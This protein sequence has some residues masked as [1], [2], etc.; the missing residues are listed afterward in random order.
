MTDGEQMASDERVR[1]VLTTPRSERPERGPLPKLGFWKEVSLSGRLPDRLQN[2][3]KDGFLTQEEAFEAETARVGRMSSKERVE[4]VLS[5]P[6][7]KRPKEGPLEKGTVRFRDTFSVPD[8]LTNEVR[9]G[10]LTLEEAKSIALERKEQKRLAR[11]AE[12]EHFEGP[13]PILHV[14]SHFDELKVHPGYLEW[15]SRW[16]KLGKFNTLPFSR[17][18]KIERR[19]A[20]HGLFIRNLHIVTTD[21]TDIELWS[22]DRENAALVTRTIYRAM[23][24]DYTK[25]GKINLG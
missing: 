18:Q 14:V 1:W 22:F 4:Y 17:I 11:L 19:P 3:I 9:N 23:S 6:V 7:E 2:E 13:E 12:H 10:Y 5:V 8:D 21:G 25:V 20:A 24:G 15:G 16:M